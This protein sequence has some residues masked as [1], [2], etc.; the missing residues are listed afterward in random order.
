MRILAVDDELVALTKMHKMLLE[1]GQCDTATSGA[2]ACK[3]YSKAISENFPYHLVTIDIQMPEI[4]G[5]ELLRMLAGLERDS[6]FRPSKK[7][8]ITSTGSPEN[9]LEAVRN[10]CDAFLVKPI[11]KDVLDDKLKELG[12]M[13]PVKA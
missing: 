3:M 4:T 11:K 13:K 1:Y 7:I 9:V 6:H 2:Q 5:F 8:I 12:L 10:K